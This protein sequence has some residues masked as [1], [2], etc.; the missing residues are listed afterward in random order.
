MERKAAINGSKTIRAMLE[1]NFRESEDNVIRFPEIHGPI[2]EKVIQYLYYK[3]R[4]MNSKG[5]IPVFD[6]E[7]EIA[8]ELLVASNYLEC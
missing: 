2:L 6:I 5:K 1:G 7:P 8:L 3:E 4:N